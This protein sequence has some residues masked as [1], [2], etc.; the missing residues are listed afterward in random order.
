[1][2][3][4][5]SLWTFVISAWTKTELLCSASY[6]ALPCTWTTFQSSPKVPFVWNK[7][8]TSIMTQDV[9][10]KV[11]TTQSC[12]TLCNPMDCGVISHFH[13]FLTP[14]IKPASPALQADSL[15][16][17][18][19]KSPKGIAILHVYKCIFFF[20]LLEKRVNSWNIEKKT[21]NHP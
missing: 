15:M 19:P 3:K 2:Y 16:S 17:E 7:C 5:P 13:L 21:K 12:P 18:P 20:I 8:L 1:M 11:L 10:G 4:P 6:W 9:K 14:G